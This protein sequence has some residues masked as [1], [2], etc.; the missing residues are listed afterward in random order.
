MQLTTSEKQLAEKISM[1]I[2]VTSKDSYNTPQYFYLLVRGD[3]MISF[4]EALKKGNFDPKE[5]A[6][7]LTW[8]YGEPSYDV[9]NEMEEKYG[10][11]IT[12]EPISIYVA[13][14]KNASA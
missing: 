4:R 6:E 14:D 3:K 2:Y 12:E 13:E 7:I 8:G 9:K 11:E 5:Y 1:V 10:L